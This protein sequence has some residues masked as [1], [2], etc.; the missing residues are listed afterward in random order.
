MT[1][2]KTT[3]EFEH[4]AHS[5]VDASLDALTLAITWSADGS[6]HQED[7]E[8]VRRELRAVR[9]RMHSATVTKY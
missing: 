2:G 6:S 3:I 4:D 1:S 5:A 9:K 7:L 8:G